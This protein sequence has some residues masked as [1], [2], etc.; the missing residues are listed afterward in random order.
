[1]LDRLFLH[2]LL[3]DL[4]LFLNLVW[5][6]PICGWYTR[7]L[8]Y[9]D[10]DICIFIQPFFLNTIS[11]R[12]TQYFN[13][14][15]FSLICFWFQCH[16]SQIICFVSLSMFFNFFGAIETILFIRFVISNV[17][18][19][20]FWR[21]IDFFLYS[22]FV[23]SSNLCMMLFFYSNSEL[24]RLLSDFKSWSIILSFVFN[25]F[26]KWSILLYLSDD[27]CTGASH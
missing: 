18:L 21:C 26:W 1:M 22:S 15:L 7:T 6:C 17:G 9:F 13:M 19:M 23:W 3:F 25:S 20:S 8:S 14:Y 5:Y 4:V 12:I 11:H 2:E 27:V 10:I 24:V 16:I